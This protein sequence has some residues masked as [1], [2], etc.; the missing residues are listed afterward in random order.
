MFIGLISRYLGLSR[1]IFGLG[2]LE[3]IRSW[4]GLIDGHPVRCGEYRTGNGS[5]PITFVDNEQV[6]ICVFF[7]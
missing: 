2:C 3:Q 1:R 4:Q 6:M 5:D 7:V